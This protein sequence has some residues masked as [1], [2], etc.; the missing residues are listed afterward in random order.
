[1][2]L[3]SEQTEAAFDLVAKGKK[4]IGPTSASRLVESFMPNIPIRIQKALKNGKTNAFNFPSLQQVMDMEFHR[5]PT[6]NDVFQ[7]CFFN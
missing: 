4:T 7:V 1:M 5:C 3:T 2:R 6:W